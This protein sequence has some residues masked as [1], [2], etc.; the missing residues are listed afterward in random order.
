VLELK[1]SQLAD[2][3]SRLGTQRESALTAHEPNAAD[4]P[5]QEYLAYNVAS[6]HACCD[7]AGQAEHIHTLALLPRLAIQRM[8][9]RPAVTAGG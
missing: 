7:R 1:N 2:N 8:L 9:Q 3:G 4:A 5:P 6:G